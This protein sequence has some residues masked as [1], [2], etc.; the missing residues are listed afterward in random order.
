MSLTP[1][2]PPSTPPDRAESPL[3]TTTT[4]REFAA[5]LALT[6]LGACAPRAAGT[7][8]APAPV[9]APVPAGGV[10]AASSPAAPGRTTDPV[11]AALVAVVTARY[12]ADV[13]P[14]RQRASFDDAVARTV[15]LSRRLRQTPVA[16]GVDP[17][18]SLCP[19]PA[20]AMSAPAPA[21][22]RRAP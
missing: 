7:L 16:N 20:R 6:A 11:S 8:P 19:A 4:R 21:D 15:E 18:A 3:A 2:S 14:E 13:V 22:A 9:P 12:G 17:F 5:A 10:T 1:P